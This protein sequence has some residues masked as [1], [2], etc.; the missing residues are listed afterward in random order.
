MG[1]KKLADLAP[2]QKMEATLAGILGIDI[3]HINIQA[4]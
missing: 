4:A 2:I 1:G 3:R